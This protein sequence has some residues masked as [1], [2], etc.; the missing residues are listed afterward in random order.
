VD[1]QSGQEGDVRSESDV[2]GDEIEDAGSRSH[3]MLDAAL[4]T[5][6]VA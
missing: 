4:D 5:T 6:G 3:A 2:G 1:A